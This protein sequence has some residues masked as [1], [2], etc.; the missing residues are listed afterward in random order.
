MA[1]KAKEE[2][3]E[4]MKSYVAPESNSD[5]SSSSDDEPKRKRKK[6]KEKD[7][8][9]PKRGMSSFMYFAQA[10]RPEVKQKHPDLKVPEV[11]KKLSEMWKEL[12]PEEKEV[13]I[14]HVEWIFQP[15]NYNSIGKTLQRKI[16]KDIKMK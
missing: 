10:K 8:N 4:K 11:G 16:K 1:L 5:E 13:R 7:P 3:D 6:K 15:Y 12:T 2:Y 14:F 9:K